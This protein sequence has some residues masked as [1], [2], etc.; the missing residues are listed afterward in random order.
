MHL[1]RVLAASALEALPEVAFAMHVL[2][3][4]TSETK[5]EGVDPSA[6]ARFFPSFASVAAYAYLPDLTRHAV[7]VGRIDDDTAIVAYLPRD[8]ALPPDLHTVAECRG[9]NTNRIL[10]AD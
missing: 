5:G 3:R 2:Y 8:L 6:P 1:P 9:A 7:V 10:W 4:R